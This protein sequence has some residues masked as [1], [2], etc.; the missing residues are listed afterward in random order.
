[1]ATRELVQKIF[2]AFGHGLHSE[3][4]VARERTSMKHRSF[5]EQTGS[6]PA[7]RFAAGLVVA[8]ML[9]HGPAFAADRFTCSLAAKLLEA[10]DRGLDNVAAGDTRGATSGIATYAREAQNMAERYSTRDPLPDDV[11]AALSAILDTATSHYFVADAA[12][13]LLEQA[14]VVQRAMPLICAETEIPDLSRHVN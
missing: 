5:S 6:P 2:T 12:P 1:M 14:L 10:T 11:A 4:P 9:A 13:A 7:R 3:L 8:L